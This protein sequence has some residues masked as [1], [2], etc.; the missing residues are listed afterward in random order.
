MRLRRLALALACWLPL[1]PATHALAQALTKLPMPQS[2]RGGELRVQWETDSNPGGTVHRLDWGVA[3]VAENSVTSLQ[4][5]AVAADRFVHRAVA[6]GLTAE[7]SYVYRVRSGATASATFAYRTAPLADTPFRMVWI[8]DNQDQ[9]STPFLSVLQQILPFVPDV[10]GHAGDTV[11]N[12]NVLL[13]WQ[14]QWFDPLAAAANLG[15]RVPILVSRG[16]HDGLFPEA[17]AY[18]WLPGSGH[19]DAETIGR[20]RVIRIDSNFVSTEQN[21][22]L[23]AELAS[24]A[25]QSADFR[26]VFFHHPPY[27]NLWSPGGT[28]Y[29]GHPYERANWVPLF[30]QHG[31]DIVVSGHSHSYQRGLQNGVIYT[32]VGGAGGALDT[33]TVDAPWPFFTV[34]Q[35]VHHYVVMD[36]SPRR[37]RWTAYH[38]SGAVLDEFTLGEGLPQIPVLPSM[39]GDE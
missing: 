23:A 11:Q 24:P 3:S 18:H 17:F 34:A 21:A 39:D 8:A 16:N 32:L 2:Y 13:E 35:G 30:E 9:A 5:I 10:I 22:W 14:T 27:T 37:L 7:T 31:V 19:Y 1:L 20:V 4:T 36:A 28:S 38:L 29:N 25:S 26:I 15:Q 6:T 33:A 12:G